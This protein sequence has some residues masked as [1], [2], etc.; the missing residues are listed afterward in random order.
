M[1]W[2]DV[3]GVILTAAL[4]TIAPDT[5]ADDVL[6]K[7]LPV[8]TSPATASPDD[9]VTDPAT[10]NMFAPLFMFAATRPASPATVPEPL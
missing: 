3:P 1:V 6:E 4:F 5:P 10:P 9:S 8:R 7:V 2:D